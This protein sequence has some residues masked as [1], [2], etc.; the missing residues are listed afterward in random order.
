MSESYLPRDLRGFPIHL[1][2]AKG[3]GMTA[4]A[5]ILAAEGAIL[6]GSDVADVFYTD[7]ILAEL[8]I[9]VAAGF[10]SA[11]LGE[12]I[13]LVIH[14]AAY[15]RDSNPELLAAAERGLPMMSYPE[16]LGE[17]S[18]RFDS[19]GIAGVH[20]KT[21][22]TAIA[23]SIVRA[24]GLPAT[25]IA[26]SAVASFGGRSTSIGGSRFL[27]AETCEYRRHFLSFKPRRIVLTSVEHD[28]QDFFPRYADI[29]AAFA[30]FIRLLPSDGE[31]VYCIDDP[32]AGEA[33]AY[34]PPGV[35]LLPYGRNA[36]GAYR[37]ESYE[38]GDGRASFRLAGFSEP[39]ELKVPGEH[40]ALDATAALAVAF[41]LLHAQTGTGPDPKAVAA[42]RAAIAAFAGSRRRS[43]ILGESAGI[44]FMDDYGHH[45]TA[46]RETLRG[47][48]AFW[49]ERR[50]VVDFMSH[51]YSRTKALF[52]DFA[53]SLD[54]ADA[55]VLHKIY[56]SAREEPDGATAG[57]ALFEAVKSRRPGR[58]A[59]YFEEPMDALGKLASEL[60]P[61]DLFLTMGAG[62][63]WKL[64]SAL[65]AEL[66][67][68][69]EA[70]G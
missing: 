33:A 43:E 59:L 5:E 60:S 35:A 57:R 22:T 36:T 23:G 8:G 48:K 17:L 37:L 44:L 12:G 14:S 30:D 45:P 4:L 3:T 21:T 32:G 58:E 41:S 20:G 38:A 54:T 62:D 2:G 25:V 40:I 26:G 28:H 9:P 47:I 27:I 39:F 50:L 65:L 19:C 24:L 29:L 53:A 51:T 63:N 10:D 7:A 64:G 11:N 56:A 67:S 68:G 55:V 13:R 34:A 42:A 31:L 61:G 1:I 49:P 70:L 66:S 16:A 46:I 15:G 6:T 52:N 18:R 69:G